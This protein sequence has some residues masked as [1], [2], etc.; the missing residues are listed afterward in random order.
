MVTAGHS[1]DSFGDFVAARQNSLLRTA[2]LLTGQWTAAEDLVQLALVKT[3]PHWERIHGDG[4][5]EAYVH[6]V[7]INSYLSWWRSPGRLRERGVADPVDRPADEPGYAGVEARDALYSVLASLPRRQRAVVVLRYYQ[8]LSEAQAAEVLGC[9]I[10]TVKSQ[11]SK[12]L[13]RLRVAL[14]AQDSAW[15]GPR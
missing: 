3:L 7:L 11:G 10:G 15:K 14:I 12:G 8:D 2:W 1:S 13:A 5:P 9:S 4:N 6:R